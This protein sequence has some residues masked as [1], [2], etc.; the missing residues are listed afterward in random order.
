[1]IRAREYPTWE[2]A[3]AASPRE[4]ETAVYRFALERGGGETRHW[5]RWAHD[6]ESLVP[7]LLA[8]VAAF[9]RAHRL[10]P[11]WA[12]P[13]SYPVHQA[14]DYVVS[15]L[16]AHLAHYTHGRPRYTP[17]HEWS[18]AMKDEH[19]VGLDTARIALI[20][21]KAITD[22]GGAVGGARAAAGRAY[23][24]HLARFYRGE[25]MTNGEIATALGVKKRSVR[26]YLSGGEG[27]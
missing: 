5:E 17:F 25:G 10:H 27:R 6:P 11:C 13:D 16:I 22:L 18:D 15:P 24:E 8:E 1:M 3:L 12:A 21:R 23:N 19:Y 20:R 4:Q 9:V 26:R 14:A 2:A 7:G